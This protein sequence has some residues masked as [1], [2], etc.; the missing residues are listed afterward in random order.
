MCPWER[1]LKVQPYHALGTL[2]GRGVVVVGRGRV[3]CFTIS[4]GNKE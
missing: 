3:S 1:F 2:K 4:I